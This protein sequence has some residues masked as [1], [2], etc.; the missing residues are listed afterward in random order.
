MRIF[1]IIVVGLFLI[2]TAL[3]GM[4]YVNEKL[5]EDHT[6]PVFK[7]EGDIV[8]VSLETTDEELLKGITAYDEKDNFLTIHKRLRKRFYLPTFSC[9]FPCLNLI[10]I[11]SH[12]TKQMPPSPFRTWRLPI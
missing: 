7:V 5:T 3:F 2:T 8:E 1:R 11:S 12:Q 9:H 10:L 6:I 4:Y